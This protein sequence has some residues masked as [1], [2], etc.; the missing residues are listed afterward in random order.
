MPDPSSENQTLSFLLRR[1]DEA[2]IRPHKKLGQNFLIDMNLHRLLLDSADL[3]END[4]VLEVGT[5]TG[6]LTVLMA[7]RAAAVITVELDEQL[8]QLAGEEL[9]GVENVFMLRTDALKSK[10]KLSPMVLDE[11]AKQ[12]AAAEGRQLKLVANLPY[13][14]AT[15]LLSNLLALDTPP[16]MMTVTIQKELADR[17]IARPGS[18][19]Y[20]AFSIWI[21]SQ[22]RSE[23]VRVMPPSAFWPQP[24]VHSAI[25]RVTLDDELRGRIPDRKFFHAFVRSMFFHRRKFLRSVLLSAF[26][27]RLNKPQVDAVLAELG[28]DGTIRA[29]TMDVEQMLRMCEAFRAEVGD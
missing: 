23:L 25:I 14:I 27:N 3:G 5:G 28:I 18:K 15:P 22:C 21:Q 13:N 7:Q 10:S 6:S 11:I 16:R 4:V 12:L 9:F 26:K 19:D 20:G 1:F 17:I 29:E 2:G 8:F 24:K